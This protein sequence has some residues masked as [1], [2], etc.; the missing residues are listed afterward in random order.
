MR[1]SRTPLLAALLLSSTT[2]LRGQTTANAS[3]HW[4][5]TISAPYGEVRI[6]V[7]LAKNAKGELAGT[8]GRPAQEVDG[9]PLQKL[10]GLP[11]S[12]VG[13]KGQEVTFELMAATGGG[14]FHGSLL[15]D[16]KSM[17]GDFVSRDSSVPFTLTRRGDARIEAPP[18][19]AAIGKE[20]EGIWNG[21]LDANG[22]QLRLVLK[23]S[24][25]A[26]GKSTG[27]IANIDEGGIESP[28]AITQKGANLALEVRTNGDTYSGALNAAGTELV[29]TYTTPQI[30]LPLTFRRAM[31]AKDKH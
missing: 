2:S 23:M 12:N 16:G 1:V 9:H 30:A 29:G 25:Q 26:D 15:A 21:T 5:G 4:E 3:G 24:N 28:V 7:D 18:R 19:S 17:S 11:L 22:R 8:F 31:A 13:V 10:K 27:S 20:M 14:T 6:E